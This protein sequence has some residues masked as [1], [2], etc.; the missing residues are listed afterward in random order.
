VRRYRYPLCLLALVALAAALRAPRLTGYNGLGGDEAYILA[1]AQ[2]P[3]L[4]MF[5]LFTFEGNGVVYPILEWPLVRVSQSLAMLRLPAFAA[6]VLAVPALVWAGSRIVGLRAAIAAAALLAVNPVAVTYSQLAR[7]Y[8]FAMLSVTV[9][10][11]CLARIDV[12]RWYWIGFVAAMTIAGYSN[13]LAV[14]IVLP[15][16]VVMVLGDKTRVR[17]WLAAL[18]A[19]AI[20]LIP[21]VVLVAVERSKRNALYWLSKPTLEDVKTLLIDFFASR[22][23]VL[24]G[25]LLVAV[26][27]VRRR[28]DTKGIWV[29]FSWGAVAPLLLFLASQVSPV[30]TRAYALPALPGALLFVAAAAS[31]LPRPVEVVGLALLGALFLQGSLFHAGDFHPPGLRSAIAALASERRAG[32]PVLFD[33][34]DGLSAAGFYDRGLQGRGRL[35]M[36]EW[37]DEPLPR[38]IV[39]R[40]DPGGYA[41]APPGPP[42]ASLIRGLA[43]HGAAYLVFYEAAQ[44]G[45]LSESPGVRWARKSCQTKT[46]RFDVNAARG[47]RGIVLMRIARCR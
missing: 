38:G 20:A 9:A 43:R 1:L 6:G 32:Q 18:T 7:P 24:V 27:L 3:L 30:F 22:Y 33:I 29:A 19:V 14:A 36:S 23:G 37:R 4:R 17:G 21:L 26:W 28:L 13:A 12:S 35:V 25:A 5:R 46:T 8:V 31:A 42:S 2:R 44:Q 47:Q 34:P 15:G 10:Y 41:K 11:G 45:D 16:Q 40:D 39:L